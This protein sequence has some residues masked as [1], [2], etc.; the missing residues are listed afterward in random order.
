MN[1]VFLKK[2]EE[3]RLL[4]GHLWIYSNEIDTKVSPLKN[5]HPGELITIKTARNK[6]L[7]VGYINP[8]TLLCV[9]LLT[10][11]PQEK[12]D[13]AFFISRIK[14]ALAL[15]KLCFTKPFYRLIFGESDQLPGLVVDRFN[16]VLV[17]QLNT[18]GMENLKELIVEALVHVL[19]PSSILWR[20]SSSIRATE[21]LP[22]YIETAYGE[23]PE[24]V[25]LEEN[26][27]RFIAAIKEG[28]KTG[29]FYDQRNNRACLAPYVK[30]KSVLDVCSYSG[31]FGIN[32]AVY[33]AQSVACVDASEF[34]LNQ[35]KQNAELNGLGNKIETICADAF[36][37]LKDLRTSQKLFDVIIL[38]PPAF[39]K[40]RKDIEI[41]T[42]AY[43]RLHRLALKILQP[44]GILITTSCS[45]HLSRD[46]LLDVLRQAMLQE[47]RNATVIEQ[48]HQAQDHP[49]HP[50]ITETDYLKG[51][52]V[53]VL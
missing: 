43:L 10:L 21:N 18:T 6:D 28:Q 34:A 32:A 30:D 38:D 41:G 49:V 42:N 35:L 50:A 46:M 48:L 40:R 44:S 23:P 22:N 12:I 33:G 53:R 27:I 26:N 20:N 14:Q 4:A 7:G 13:C 31:G 1:S 29:W 3:R 47:N 2:N 19:D 17:A 36:Q 37:A 39:I 5:F 51:F 15:R 16:N 52:I 25:E 24:Q 11:D 9:R 8:N 45:L